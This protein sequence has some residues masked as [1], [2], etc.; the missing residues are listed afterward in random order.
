MISHEK[1]YFSVNERGSRKMITPQKPHIYR[2]GHWL[3]EKSEPSVTTL[4][5]HM[6]VFRHTNFIKEVH[7]FA[8]QEAEK[9]AERLNQK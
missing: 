6:L 5:G 2:Q 1:G 3:V 7:D 9:F 8:N 4:I